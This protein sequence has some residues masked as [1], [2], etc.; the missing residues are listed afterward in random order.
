MGNNIY[1]DRLIFDY[2]K[3]ITNS[4]QANFEIIILHAYNT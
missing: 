4:I 1:V 2:I 3:F